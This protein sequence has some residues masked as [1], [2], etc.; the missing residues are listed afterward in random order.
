MLEEA[1]DVATYFDTIHVTFRRVGNT[2]RVNNMA[3]LG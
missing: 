1:I 2:K 3:I